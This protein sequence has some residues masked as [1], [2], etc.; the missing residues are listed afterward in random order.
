MNEL[1]DVPACWEWPLPPL[2]QP[3]GRH[4]LLKWQDDHCAICDV[5]TCGIGARRGQMLLVEDHDH[6]TGETRGYLCTRCNTQE[7]RS[8]APVFD[9]YRTRPPVMLIGI[10]QQYHRSHHPIT[11]RADTEWENALDDLA[12]FYEVQRA[13]A[14]RAAHAATYS[15]GGGVLSKPQPLPE[16]TPLMAAAH[17]VG[18]TWG[19]WYGEDPPIRNRWRYRTGRDR[20][21]DRHTEA[22]RQELAAWV[23]SQH[24][25][26]LRFQFV[27]KPLR[28]FRSVA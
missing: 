6:E 25:I 7:G 27:T 17:R 21:Q 4:I 10:P 3:N 5:K 11:K 28:G 1:P 18:L 23:R 26:E 14:R 8:A 22:Y 24:T 12:E 20:H 9:R 15:D 16:M 19:E 2:P 13:N